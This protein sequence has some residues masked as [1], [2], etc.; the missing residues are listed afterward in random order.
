MA[1]TEVNAHPLW[2]QECEGKHEFFSTSAWPTERI[3]VLSI[4]VVEPDT[5]GELTGITGRSRERDLDEMHKAA[6]TAAGIVAQLPSV[7]GFDP[8]SAAQMV[9]L[10]N[11]AV[12]RGGAPTSSRRGGLHRRVSGGC[13]RDGRVRRGPPP[14]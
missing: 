8:L 6:D 3:F 7:F 4:P 5:A 14:R 13:V 9:W 2:R 12:S 10:W 1:G 11:R